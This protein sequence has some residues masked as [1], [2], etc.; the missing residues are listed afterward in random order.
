M[1]LCLRPTHFCSMHTDIKTNK[2][3]NRIQIRTYKSRQ[4]GMGSSYTVLNYYSLKG[5]KKILIPI[6]SNKYCFMSLN[7]PK[8]FL[9]HRLEQL[10]PTNVIFR[11]RPQDLD[12]SIPPRYREA[13]PLLCSSQVDQVQLNKGLGGLPGLHP[14]KKYQNLYKPS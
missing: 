6:R 10:F 7:F 5:K 11:S 14:S 2:C 9:S 3:P 1:Y 8:V 4:L 12:S 13:W